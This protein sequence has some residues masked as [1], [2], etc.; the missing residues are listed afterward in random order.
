MLVGKLPEP[1]P[2]ARPLLITPYAPGCAPIV[3]DP[4]KMGPLTRAY[5]VCPCKE[6]AG[7]G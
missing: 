6:V 4:L 5:A 3:D 1:A 7:W 2:P